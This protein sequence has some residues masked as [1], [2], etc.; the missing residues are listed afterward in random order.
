MIQS[1]KKILKYAT[2]QATFFWKSFVYSEKF[3]IFANEY[4]NLTMS[5]E[6]E[7][8]EQM[9]GMAAEPAVVYPVRPGSNGITYVHD[10]LDDLDWSRIPIL[11]PK[12][13]EEAIARIEKAE[14]EMDDPTKWVTS[15]QMW[16]ELHQKFPWLQ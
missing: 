8:I 15:E 12:T 1:Y 5:E 16:A 6:I 14:A 11:G 13:I 4:N 2:F 9:V 3:C 7:D 10:E